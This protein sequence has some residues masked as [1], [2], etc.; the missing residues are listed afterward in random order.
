MP[1]SSNLETAPTTPDHFGNVEKREDREEPSVTESTADRNPF[2]RLAEEFAAQI[3]RGEHPSLTDYVKRYPE[4][5]ADIRDLFPA[6]ALI[7]QH[8]PAPQERNGSLDAASP[9]ARDN[10]LSHLGD[11]RILRYLGEGGMGVVYEAVRESLRSHVALKVMHPQYRNRPNYLRRFHTEARSA[12]RLHHTNIVSVFDY[13]EHDGVCYYATQFIAGQ[14]L[15]KVLED[16]RRLR[17]EKDGLP[18][19]DATTVACTIDGETGQVDLA[20]VDRAPCPTSALQQTVALGLLTGQ[21]ATPRPDEDSGAH[22]A[23]L[24]GAPP[25]EPGAHSP[26]LGKQTRAFLSELHC[27]EAMIHLPD[28]LPPASEN[29]ARPERMSQNETTSFLTATADL[30]YFR[31]VARLGAQVAD[32]LEHAHKRGVL[33]RDIKP[34]NLILDPHG[35]IWVTDFGLA[36]FEAGD[37]VSKWQ[38]LVGT[39][40]Y[41]A[42]ERFRGVSDRAGDIYA[43]GATLYELLTFRPAFEGKDQLELICRIEN[44]RPVPPRQLDRKIPRDLET[45]VLK[46]LAKDPEQRFATAL[47]L[48]TELRR[49]LGN[50]PIRSRPVS[51][52][53]QFRLWCKRNPRLAAANIAAAT[54]T[55][56]LAIVSTILFIIYRDK[57]HQ[58]LQA[59]LRIQQEQRKTREQLVQALNDR[60]RAGRF[61]RQMGQRFGGLDA[62]TKASEIARELNLPPDRLDSLRDEAIACLAL[63]DLQRVGRAIP[64]P[65]GVI[66]W[67]FDSNMTRYALRFR[68]GTIQ[69]RRI[70]DGQEIDRFQAQGDRDHHL[71]FSPDGRYVATTNS[72]TWSMT[73]RD[74]ERRAVTVDHQPAVSHGHAMKFSPD[75][76][77]IV[78]GHDH[79]ELAVYDLKTGRPCRPWRVPAVP[80]E[81]AFHPSGARIA[82]LCAEKANRV[83]LILD[84][85]SGER[86][87]SI[88]LRPAVNGLAWSP[89]GRT[90]ATPSD[91]HKIYLW[92]TLTGICRATLE[93]HV[94]VVHVAAFDPSGALLKSYGWEGRMWLWDA[95]LARPWLHE[96]FLTLDIAPSSHGRIVVGS[97]DKLTTYELD[98]ALEYRTL[99]SAASPPRDYNRI[100]IHRDGRLLALGTSDGVVLWDLAS[101]RELAFL[102]IG[103]AWSSTFSPT[104]DLLTSGAA[105]AWQWPVQIGKDPDDFRI[106]PARQLPLPASANAIEADPSGRIVAL[107]CHAYVRVLTTDRS[108]T[109]EPLDDCRSVAVSPNGQWLATGSASGGAGISRVEDAKEIATLPTELGTGV[110][111]SRDGKSLLTASPPCQVWSVGKWDEPRR[112]IGGHGLCFSTDSSLV[113]VADADMAIRLVDNE[114]G[115]TLARLKSPDLCAVTTAAFSPDG[116][117]LVLSTQDG[118][119]VHVWDLRAIRKHLAGMG[120]DWHAPPYSEDEPA[121]PRALALPTPRVD[122]G[123]LRPTE[124]AASAIVQNATTKGTELACQ[125][126]WVEAAAVFAQAAADAQPHDQCLRFELAILRLAIADLAGYRSTC[127]DMLESL[128]RTTDPVSLEFTAHACVLAPRSRSEA[129][130]ALRLAQ[131]RLSILATPWSDHVLGLALY[132]VGRYADAIA[133]LDTSL[134]IQPAR[135]D[136]NVL[137]WLGLALAHFKLG[138]PDEARRWLD[139]VERWVDNARLRDRPG[140]IDRAVPE[141]WK[142][143]D[144]IMMH[145]L[146][147]EARALLSQDIDTVPANVFAEP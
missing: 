145:L 26:D 1:P 93:G 72:P 138:Q 80:L 129:L 77:R 114:T 43:L 33:H 130:D 134:K 88:P 5:A 123:P 121:G 49:F 70:A 92:D 135:D 7:E 147:R 101:G 122:Y 81:L 65:T 100:S 117:K 141:V 102:R 111:F 66:L 67:A 137:N 61:S 13:G 99:K 140:G 57:N 17:T 128:D 62:L 48:S 56:T 94:S 27:A 21:F 53:Q 19:A 91:D 118:P 8:K 59:N 30:G 86:V 87:R 50:L 106:G 78:V 110:Q 32:A 115:R 105:G 10:L 113:A 46:T 136:L 15:D 69:V 103:L 90:L 6:L 39:L 146:Q 47:E 45:I 60:A 18:I 84:A 75:S 89:D 120:L 133:A 79:G 83:C 4:H 37:D 71:F 131:R 31:E 16:I 143:R 55:T 29:A 44:V 36:K 25:V 68:D 109:I 54:L 119:A 98:A 125:G 107:A 2:E 20:A 116:S 144:A 3:R 104:G 24:Q 11:Y 95:A 96:R 112:A 51:Y 97:E 139:R 82:V 58:A 14:S 9:A 40:R 108:F 28:E 41:M 23:L 42:P 64:K 74:V 38:D 85:A 34:P 142:F 12:A 126:E 22:D 52:P 73:A 63:P 127:R 76:G 35:N 132:R 124:I